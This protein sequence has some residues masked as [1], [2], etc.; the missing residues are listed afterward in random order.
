MN[1]LIFR[2]K[3]LVLWLQSFLIKCGIYGI[4]MYFMESCVNIFSMRFSFH[5]YFISVLIIYGKYL[6]IS[7]AWYLSF[8]LTRAV[9]A[10]LPF[11]VKGFFCHLHVFLFLLLFSQRLLFPV[12]YTICIYI[13]YIYCADSHTKW[14][15]NV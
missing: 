10:T 11:T 7:V 15:H 6:S 5:N 4:H 8:S 3:I 1:M 12:Y 14:K 9:S 2:E 13:Y